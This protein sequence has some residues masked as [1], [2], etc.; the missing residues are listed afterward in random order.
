[1]EKDNGRT[2]FIHSATFLPLARW[3]NLLPFLMLSS[4][5]MKQAK[6]SEGAVDYA[7]KGDF[8]RRRFWTLSVWENREL[9]RKFVVAEP[10][11]IAVKK[12]AVWAG[13]GAAFTE[14][15]SDSRAINWDEAMRKLENPTFYYD[16]GQKR[17]NANADST[18]S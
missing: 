10:H 12:F 6:R 14:W 3:R 18:V 2:R 16:N 4:K 1:V 17:R 13:D 7:V 8:P 11:R 9:M 15:T 5:V